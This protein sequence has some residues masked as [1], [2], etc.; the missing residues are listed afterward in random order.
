[1]LLAAKSRPAYTPCEGEDYADQ[2]AYSEL[3]IMVLH[4][5]ESEMSGLIDIERG[6]SQS[7]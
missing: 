3:L 5:V 1:M 6:G 7:D 2:D 4:K